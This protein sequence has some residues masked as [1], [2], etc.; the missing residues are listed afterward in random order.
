MGRSIRAADS[1]SR[2]E[3]FKNI[4][5]IFR[6]SG[7]AHFLL[8]L[9]ESGVDFVAADMPNANRLTVGIMAMVA[10]DEAQRISQRTKDALAAAKRRG[11]KFR[12][13]CG[14][15]PNARSHTCGAHGWS[16]VARLDRK[17]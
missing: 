14:V 10:E 13:D 9:K 4:F 15:I 3:R 16:P 8:G 17:T 12:V 7:N 11:V 5:S 2:T 1:G 6:L